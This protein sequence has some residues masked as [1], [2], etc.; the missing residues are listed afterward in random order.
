[1]KK[2][3]ALVGILAALAVLNACSDD[4][5]E[6][7]L[8]VYTEWKSTN[9][10]WLKKI[11]NKT[12]PD[13]TPYYTTVV[14]SWNPGVYVLMHYFNDPAETADNL[15]PLYT[16]TVDV[17]YIGYTCEDVPFDSSTLVNSYGKLGIARFQCNSVVQGW[18]IA[19]EKMHVGDTCEVIVPYN[20]G[21]GSSTSGTLPPF[22]TMRFN[23][24]LED[25][26]KYEAK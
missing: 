22:T 12:N 7:L 20:V 5:N 1:M 10:E 19:L 11:A 17:R 24:R 15:V 13:G 23:I 3:L 6:K 9:D 18:T 8:E 25:I 4:E 2:L 16:S 26:Y 14:P 21:Y